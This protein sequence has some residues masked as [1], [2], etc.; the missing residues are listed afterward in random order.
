MIA[1]P[2]QAQGGVDQ[3]TTV[4]PRRVVLTPAAVTEILDGAA[5][6]EQFWLD[7]GG[8]RR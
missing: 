1:A 6:T 4:S 5:G 2:R 3:Q 7:R 8:A